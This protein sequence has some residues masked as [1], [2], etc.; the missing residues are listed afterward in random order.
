MALVID[1]EEKI[2]APIGKVWEALND[3]A[4]ARAASPDSPRAAPT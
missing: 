4:M 3:P 2:A 1:G